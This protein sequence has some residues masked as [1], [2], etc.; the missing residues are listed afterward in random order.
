LQ[1]REHGG[2]G[3]IARGHFRE[4]EQR[5]QADLSVGIVPPLA[6]CNSAIQQITN[7]RYTGTLEILA[8]REDA[9]G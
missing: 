9:E 3:G 7:L 1:H 2:A 5:G 8:A 6:E 4:R